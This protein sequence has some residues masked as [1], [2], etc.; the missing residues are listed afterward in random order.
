MNQLEERKQLKL[1]I[2]TCEELIKYRIE[3]IR[4]ARKATK[5]DTK[6]ISR[7]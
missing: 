1:Q 4:I 5:Q 3:G 6:T 2:N 7:Q